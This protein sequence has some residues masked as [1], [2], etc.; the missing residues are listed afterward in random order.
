MLYSFSN[1][2]STIPLK[3]EGFVVVVVLGLVCLFLP[4][5]VQMGCSTE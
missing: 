2:I 5:A 3:L 4:P 1:T